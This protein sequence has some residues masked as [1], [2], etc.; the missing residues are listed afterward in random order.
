MRDELPQSERV[1]ILAPYGRDGDLISAVLRQAGINGEVCSSIESL[2]SRVREGA[3]AAIVTDESLSA[4][5]I[6]EFAG[7]LEQQPQW[8]DFPVVIMTSGGEQTE[9]S[10]RRLRALGP[11]GNVTLLERPLRRVTLVSSLRA[12][13]RARRHQYQI[14]DHLLQ[15]QEA[16]RAVQERE[17]RYRFLAESIPQMV[18]T[19]TP[20]GALDYVS[21]QVTRYFGT[22]GAMVLDAGWLRWVHPQDR[23]HTKQ[24]WNHSLQT[25]EPYETS[26]RLLRASDTSWRWHLVR[27]TPRF[28]QA[29]AV[30]QWF[31]TCTDIEDQKQAQAHLYQQWHTFDTALSHTPDFTYMFNLQ[32]RFTYANRPLLALWEKPLDQVL[33]R[34]FLDLG[35]PPELAGQLQVQIQQVIDSKRALRDQGAFAG[36]SGGARKYEYIF[37]PVF[38][39]DGEVQVVAGSTRDVTERSNMEN[40]VQE[41]RRR[42]RDLLLKSPAAIALLRGPEHTFEWVNDGYVRLLGRPAASIVGKNIR[43]ALPEVE[44]QVYIGLLDTVY[45]TGEPFVGQESLVR[46]DSGNGVLQDKYVNFVYA[47]TRS[48]SGEID[49]LFA[50]ATDVTDMVLARQRIEESER[51]FRTLAES[52]PHLAWMADDTGHIFWYNRRW[53]DYTGRS[54]QEMEGWGWQSVHDPNER[55]KV[56]ERWK[57]SIVRGQAFEMMF[58]LK[59]ADGQFRSF[60][61]RVEP[62]RD[63]H[64]AVVRWF[65]TNTDITTQKQTEEELRKTNRELEEFAYVASHDLQEPLRMVNTYTQLLLRRHVDPDNLD[66]QTH[67]R[68][69]REGVSRMEQLIHDLLSYSRAANRDEL[70]STTKQSTADL[71]ASWAE[72]LAVMKDPIVTSGAQIVTGPLP[73][74]RGDTNQL[75][76]VFQNL[77]SNTLK[78]RREAV[79]PYVKISAESQNGMWV[80]AVQ[81]NG[82][83]F[84]QQYAERIFKLFKRLHRDE[85]PGTGLG[86]AICQRIVERY[87]G[88]IWAESEPGVGST[89]FVAL[90]PA[91]EQ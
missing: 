33:G 55:P 43:E 89:F 16:A 64:G 35:Y 52:I 58:P 54:A 23:E 34:N 3:G 83:G 74:V 65:G 12:G 48:L 66:A 82:I 72:A 91:P 90:P 22:D 8:S 53:Y 17:Q 27:A 40:I 20:E 56:L 50:H 87:E 57:D 32:G 4:T 51:Q 85:Y 37:V 21:Q 38:G 67:A 10:N 73:K 39:N 25:G 78:Y 14:R 41:D 5:A 28:G 11:L 36:A 24:R 61:T 29:G 9:A 26:F 46:L 13:L 81:D 45:S 19:A 31:G 60:L 47:A 1:L 2:T 69:I 86:L 42:W 62:V 59:R 68:F 75:S 71:N 49:G 80:I 84:E 79:P 76:H 18:W 63:S 77:L 30:L 6:K 15:I 70:I 88:R 44:G 7:V